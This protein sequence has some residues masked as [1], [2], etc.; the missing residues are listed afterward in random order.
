MKN[1]DEL[2]HFVIGQSE[3]YGEQIVDILRKEMQYILSQPEFFAH[4]EEGLQGSI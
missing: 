3:L 4:N 2:R 1:G